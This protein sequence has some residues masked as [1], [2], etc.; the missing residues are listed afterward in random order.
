MS[1]VD[2]SALLVSG[3]QGIPKRKRSGQDLKDAMSDYLDQDLSEL[4]DIPK[5]LKP[6]F[7]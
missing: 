6:L 5:V 4:E 3:S 1:A 7:I 2:L